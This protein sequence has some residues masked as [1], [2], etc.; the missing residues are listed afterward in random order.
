MREE[1]APRLQLL[2]IAFS[3]GVVVEG[4]P[5]FAMPVRLHRPCANLLNAPAVS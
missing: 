1:F 3:F 4:A 2:L 5:C